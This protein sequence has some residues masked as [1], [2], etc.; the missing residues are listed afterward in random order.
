MMDG[1]L[2]NSDN[3]VKKL[4]CSHWSIFTHKKSNFLIFSRTQFLKRVQ[5]DIMF[6]VIKT[7]TTEDK[8]RVSV[9]EKEMQ[10]WFR[11]ISFI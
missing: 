3:S 2:S 6:C 9:D 5:I 7:W 8:K 11:A 4:I 10:N 1:P